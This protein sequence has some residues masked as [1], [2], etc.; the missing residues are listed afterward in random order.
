M[1]SILD[2][3]ASAGRA[4]NDVQYEPGTPCARPYLWL[5]CKEEVS[6]DLFED[7]GVSTLHVALSDRRDPL[8]VSATRERSFRLHVALVLRRCIKG[9]LLAW[10]TPCRLDTWRSNGWTT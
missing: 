8:R 3:G 5:S 6:T 2:L 7:D 1:D 9:P 10:T 4:L